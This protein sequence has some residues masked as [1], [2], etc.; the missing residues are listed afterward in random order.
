MSGLGSMWRSIWRFHGLLAGILVLEYTLAF[1]IVLTATGVLV[2]RAKAISE[3]SGVDEQGLYV[4]QGFGINQPVHRAELF[5]ARSRF[6]ALAGKQ[7]VAVGSS[8]PFLGMYR[9]TLQVSAA[10]DPQHAAPQY[11]DTYMGDFDFATVLGL[12]ILKGRWFHVDEIALRYADN[13]HLVVLSESLAKRLFHDVNPVGKQVDIAGDLHTVI[14]VV[15]SLAAPQYLG[16]PR[17]TYT[18]VLPKIASS[19]NL[20][21][22]RYTQAAADLEP[23]LAALR[24]DDAGKV[25]WRLTPYPSVRSSYF[26]T[27]RLTVAALAIV[28]LAVLLTALC[29]ILGL[30]N[31]WVAKRQPQIAIRRA[32]GARKQDIQRHFLTESGLL[33]ATGLLLG[34]VLKFSLD[35][36]FGDM[37]VQDSWS[38]WLFSIVIVLL[39]AMLVVYTSLRRWLRLDPAELMRR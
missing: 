27:D 10:N 7:N 12:R 33:V 36:L 30:T 18:L 16:N 28:V 19:Q 3:I 31:Y 25:R 34:I 8:A 17:T 4:L 23:V 24:K 35:V 29:G 15:N 26:R 37:H 13:S 5:D 9:R 38:M 22:I 14:G 21:L 11:V 32:L 2:S 39:M 20:L 6:A 1:V